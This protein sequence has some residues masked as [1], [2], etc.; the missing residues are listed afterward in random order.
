MTEFKPGDKVKFVDKY[1]KLQRGV[2]DSLG[3]YPAIGADGKMTE[4]PSDIVK[5]RPFADLG[6]DMEVLCSC[7]T[8]NLEMDT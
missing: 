1:G 4:S 2:Y 3:S 5:A 8:G 6:D 7:G